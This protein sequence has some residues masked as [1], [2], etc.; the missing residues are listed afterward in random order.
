MTFPAV[1]RS[2][3]LSWST[4]LWSEASISSFPVF[5]WCS[6]QRLCSPQT[7]SVGP[8]W[9]TAADWPAVSS[10]LNWPPCAVCPP[11]H[12]RS[13]SHTPKAA[14]LKETTRFGLFWVAVWCHVLPKCSQ[15]GEFEQLPQCTQIFEKTWEF[16]LSRFQEI[17]V[18]HLKDCFT[19]STFQGITDCLLDRL[20]ANGLREFDPK[21]DSTKQANE[22]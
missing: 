21:C 9:W 10:L 2:L 14:G 5:I 11:S 15:V 6:C 19:E 8:A 18:S 22:K 12:S 13:E 7:S 1:T 3:A 17:L 4:E 20:K 16:T